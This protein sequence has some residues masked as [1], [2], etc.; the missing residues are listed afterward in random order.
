MNEAALHK[1]SGQLG[2]RFRLTSLVQKRLVQLMIARDEVITKNSGGRPV[3]LV[4][5]QVAGGRL[6]LFS[7]EGEEITPTADAEPADAP[8]EADE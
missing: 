3:R 1:L 5:D 4:V 6:Q 8:G 7:P 2:G